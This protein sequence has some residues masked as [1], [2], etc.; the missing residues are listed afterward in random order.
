MQ[1]QIKEVSSV[2]IDVK[3]IVV[4]ETRVIMIVIKEG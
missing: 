3:H 4:D 1:D 2:Y